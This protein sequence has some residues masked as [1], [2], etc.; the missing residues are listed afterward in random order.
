MLKG[1][2]NELQAGDA[3]HLNTDVGEV[4]DTAAQ[5][6]LKNY[7]SDHPA[8]FQISSRVSLLRQR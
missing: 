4:I 5:E 8:A 3:W 6:K 2:M 1:A 7:V